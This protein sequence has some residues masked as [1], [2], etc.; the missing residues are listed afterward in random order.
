MLIANHAR[1]RERDWRVHCDKRINSQAP[2]VWG[3]L[4]SAIKAYV[5]RVNEHYKANAAR[6]LNI[7]EEPSGSDGGFSVQTECCPQLSLDIDFNREAQL[8]E[9][10]YAERK[11][12]Q[13]GEDDLPHQGVF[14]GFH[15]D[16]QNNVSLALEGNPMTIDE[17]SQLLLMPLIKL[18][19]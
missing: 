9:C 16:D 4:Q 18:K 10:R 7:N 19:G 15:V 1:W 2:L 13:S 5:Q 14:L 11:S 3:K 8:I 17:V 6:C 12:R